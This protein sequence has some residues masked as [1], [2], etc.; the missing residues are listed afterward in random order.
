MNPFCHE[1]VRSEH[2]Y[3]ILKWVGFLIVVG[4][5]VVIAINTS[6][7]NKDSKNKTNENAIERNKQSLTTQKNKSENSNTK[8]LVI[9][10]YCFMAL[11]FAIQIIS[12]FNKYL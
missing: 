6:N 1:K 7:I 5:L 2:N 10:F 4:L 8:M 12:L 3:T 11:I 9:L